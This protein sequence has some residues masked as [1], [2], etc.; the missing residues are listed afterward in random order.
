MWIGRTYALDVAVREVHIVQLMDC[1]HDDRKLFF[2]IS[3]A[4]GDV[5]KGHSQSCKSRQCVP[6]SSCSVPRDT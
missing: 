1:A 5:F 4:Q 6:R 2:R 3:E